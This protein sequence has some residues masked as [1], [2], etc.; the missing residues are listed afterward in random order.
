MSELDKISQRIVDLAEEYMELN[1]TAF[2]AS[3]KLD[4]I[5][6]LDKRLSKLNIDIARRRLVNQQPDLITEYEA[7]LQNKSILEGYKLLIDALK[8]RLMA[9]TSEN[10]LKL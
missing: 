2:G 6:V 8:S 7:Y 10:K 9:L 5:I 3:F 4:K 1:T